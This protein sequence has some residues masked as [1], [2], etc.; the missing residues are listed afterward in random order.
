MFTR[1]L[2]LVISLSK[3]LFQ[4]DPVFWQDNEDLDMTFYEEHERWELL[5]GHNA[6]KRIVTFDCCPGNYPSLIFN[7]HFKEISDDD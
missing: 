5:S 4:L 2:F 7:F 6:V 3:L 1:G